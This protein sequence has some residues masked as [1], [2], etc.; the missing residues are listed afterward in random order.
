MAWKVFKYVLPYMIKNKR[1]FKTY[2][3]IKNLYRFYYQGRLPQVGKFFTVYPQNDAESTELAKD[4]NDLMGIIGL[5]PSNFPAVPNDV[6]IGDAL[7]LYGRY[8]GH[9]NNAYYD[10]M[11]P[12]GDQLNEDRSAVCPFVQDGIDVRWE[13]EGVTLVE[14]WNKRPTTWAK[15][16]E[17]IPDLSIYRDKLNNEGKDIMATE[18]SS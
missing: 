3:N 10:R 15:I 7:G 14:N 12:W 16:Q 2:S 4:L 5:D 9:D 13:K 1:H 17:Y 8:E 18:P 6:K 11:V